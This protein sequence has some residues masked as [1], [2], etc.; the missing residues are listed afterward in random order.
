MVEAHGVDTVGRMFA[1]STG[2]AKHAA[3]SRRWRLQSKAMLASHVVD[4]RAVTHPSAGL[5]SMRR[6]NFTVR[7]AMLLSA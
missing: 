3:R 5:P 2:R 4:E 6:C 7:A 1:G